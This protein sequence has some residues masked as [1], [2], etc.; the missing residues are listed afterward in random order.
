MEAEIML[1]LTPIGR[2]DS[3]RWAGAYTRSPEAAAG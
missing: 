3:M 1:N 2:P